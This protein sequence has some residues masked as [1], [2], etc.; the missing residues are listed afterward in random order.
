MAG[1]SHDESEELI[2]PS[3]VELVKS[4]KKKP[5]MVY[6]SGEKKSGLLSPIT[7]PPENNECIET[8]MEVSGADLHLH[9]EGFMENGYLRIRNNYQV[10]FAENVALIDEDHPLDIN[11]PEAENYP[12]R[13]VLESAKYYVQINILLE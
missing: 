5:K 11:L 13:I 3:N 12:Y 1:C 4:G 10:I 9:F 7:N 2:Q 8:T 6:S